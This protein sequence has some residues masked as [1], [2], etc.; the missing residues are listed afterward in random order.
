MSVHLRVLIVDDESG[1]R[2]FLRKRLAPY[3]E[4]EIVAEAIS[5]A[6][7]FVFCRSLRP[8]VIFL[9]ISMPQVDGFGLFAMLPVETRPEIVFVTAHADRAAEAFELHALDYLLK[10]YSAKR[11]AATVNKLKRHF[12]GRAAAKSAGGAWP[13]SD[14]APE[15]ALW[16]QSEKEMLQVKLTDIVLIESEDSYSR[17]TLITGKAFILRQTLSRWAEKLPD[18]DFFRIDRFRIIN[19]THVKNFERLSRDQALVHLLGVSAPRELRRQSILRLAKR[20]KNY[21]IG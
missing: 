1:A 19:L 13:L 8:D 6:S 3:P 4:I 20:L 21:V 7:A 2:D 10:P 15:G 12:V 17:L 9:D 16:V 18:T 5:V 14:S 11:M